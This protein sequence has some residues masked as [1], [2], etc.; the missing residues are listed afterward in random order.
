MGAFA[1]NTL[2]ASEHL[3]Q[4]NMNW[5]SAMRPYRTRKLV[6]AMGLAWAC[7]VPAAKATTSAT[8]SD[9]RAG[10]AA[11]VP[12]CAAL[13]RLDWP[14]TTL[15]SVERAE[16]STSNAQ[17]GPLPAHCIIRG[18]MFPRTG[19]D[20][21]RYS[22]GFEL[23]LPLA[24]NGR[25]VFQGGGGVDGTIRP[26]IGSLRK[27]VMPAL[28]Q[29]AAVVTSDMGHT[30]V[31]N[32]DARFGLD[33]QA[34]LDWGYNALDKVTG[35]AKEI[36][37]RFYGVAP[38]HA[39]FIGTS[40]GGRQGMILAQRFP[41]HFDGIVSGAP[42]LEQHLAQ[43]GSMQ[44]LREF[45]AIAP[46]DSN[47]KPILSQAFSDAD[48][49]LIAAGLLRRCDALDGAADG[50][51]E[52]Y[53]ACQYSVAEL[54]CP[55]A[56][57]AHC[58]SS[59][60]VTAFDKVMAGPRNSAGKLLYPGVP[61]ESII[62]EPEW[63]QQNIGSSTTAVPNSRKANNQSIKYLFMT[64]P[65]PDFD[66]LNFDMDT[67]PARL[68]ASAVFSAGNST[69][70]EGFKRR[71][72]KQLIFVGLGD[73]LVNPAGV[74][75]W[76]RELVAANG[77]LEATQQFARF[78][79]VPGMG[80]TDGGQSL[81]VFDPVTPLIDWVEKGVAPDRIM[82]QGSRFPGRTRALCAYPKIARYVGAGSVDDAASFRCVDP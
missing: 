77:G 69:N 61:W 6:F 75:R 11:L 60:Q 62:G 19:L 33:P 65:A 76:Y 48:L 58:L 68:A 45:S 55:G 81:D 13:Q 4:Q 35:L 8:T 20:G 53:P 24:W 52:N 7:G 16:A 49:Q 39:Y 78:F 27:G 37:T 17:G 15:K 59:A 38:R 5:R 14:H 12:D 74:N 40:G 70:Y 71:G 34:R 56:K 9:P 31:N 73:A 50:L 80:H 63:R 30:G 21:V 46:K 41:H 57:E 2:M 3:P 42:I 23:R 47:G 54:Q 1:A 79:N 67:D 29:G 25:F 64:P 18:E 22:M 43:L 44:M 72:G 10:S 66:Y 36:I 82:A 51:I 28:A 26:A 32:T